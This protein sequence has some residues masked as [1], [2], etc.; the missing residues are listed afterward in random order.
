MVAT[1]LK[2]FPKPAQ[3]ASAEQAHFFRNPISAGASRV[4]TETVSL[5]EDSTERGSTYPMSGIISYAQN[6]EDILLWRALRDLSGGFYIDVGAEDPTQNS[7]TRAFYERGWHGI[8]V[9]PV[10][11]PGSHQDIL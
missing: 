3:A 7:V 8:N 4:V 11:A 5:H 2:R 10:P 6:R 1:F 9:E